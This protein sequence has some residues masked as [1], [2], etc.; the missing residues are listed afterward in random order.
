[1]AA[2]EALAA[3]LDE[4]PDSIQVSMLLFNF[5]FNGSG[6]LTCRNICRSCLRMLPSVHQKLGDHRDPPEF[7][8]PTVIT[9]YVC[10][11][12]LPFSSIRLVSRLFQLV[13]IFAGNSFNFIFFIHS[14]CRCWWGH[15][16]PLVVG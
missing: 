15:F 2:G 1:M 10:R 11:R 7:T 8:A 5:D 3:A 14:R 4:N 13:L 16:R 9:A 12:R 6:V